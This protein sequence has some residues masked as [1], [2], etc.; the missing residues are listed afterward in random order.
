MGYLAFAAALEAFIADL[1]LHRSSTADESVGTESSHETIIT[2]I[3][4]AVTEIRS[5]KPRLPGF[6]GLHRSKC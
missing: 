4:R 6:F 2:S 3:R 5:Y 1:L